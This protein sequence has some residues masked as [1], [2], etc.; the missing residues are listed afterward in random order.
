[1][2]SFTE[3]FKRKLWSSRREDPDV[4][5]EVNVDTD[6]FNAGLGQVVKPMRSRGK[7]VY[8]IK[9]NNY[10]DILGVKWNERILNQNGDFGHV[11]K[12]TVKYWLSQRN[13]IVEYKYIGGKY[14]KSEI[15]DSHVTVFSF[16]IFS[17]NTFIF[18][19]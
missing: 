3:I 9:D 1:M 18:H 11:V 2:A 14:F 17:S 6:V 15:E 16:E 13:S 5:I 10:L 7:E 8:A 4:Q 19:N 12:G